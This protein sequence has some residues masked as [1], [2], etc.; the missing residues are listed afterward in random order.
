M[1]VSLFEF[2]HLLCFSKF[3]QSYFACRL[4]ESCRPCIVLTLAFKD[5]CL[6]L[7]VIEFSENRENF[8]YL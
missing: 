2:T 1:H 8:T 3:Q 6:K 4:C 5:A 7:H